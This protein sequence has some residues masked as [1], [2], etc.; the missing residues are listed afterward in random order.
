VLDTVSLEKDKQDYVALGETKMEKEQLD[1]IGCANIA[2][3]LISVNE[4]KSKE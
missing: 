1:V 4:G 3:I 2:S